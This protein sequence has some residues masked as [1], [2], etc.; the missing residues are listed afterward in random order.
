MVPVNPASYI[1]DGYFIHPVPSLV[2][3]PG[4]GYSSGYFPGVFHTGID[5]ADGC[6]GT[7]VR[8]SAD[9]DIVK[10][11]SGR[12]NTYPYSYEYGNYAMIKHTN[13]MYSFYG[14]LR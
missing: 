4:F 6:R 11:V 12:P 3:Y 2:G 8:A 7:A 5:Y 10:R 1:G 9:G 13:N 14:H